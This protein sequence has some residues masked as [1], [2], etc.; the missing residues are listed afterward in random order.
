MMCDSF[1]GVMV[2]V[3]GVS[4]VNFKASWR[5][6]KKMIER[7]QRAGNGFLKQVSVDWNFPLL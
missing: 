7:W 5:V 4:G 3:L 2:A 6:I 1:S